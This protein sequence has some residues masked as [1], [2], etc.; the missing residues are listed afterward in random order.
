MGRAGDGSTEQRTYAGSHERR[1]VPALLRDLVDETR[2]LLQEEVRLAKVETRETLS[3][4]GRNLTGIAI[5][6]GLGL[7]ALLALAVA[8]NR[9]LTVLLAQGMPLEVAVWLAPL[10]IAMVFGVACAVLVSRGVKTIQNQSLV[11][12]KTRQTLK[13]DKEWLRSKTH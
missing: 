6:A 11:P 5:G 4:I 8:L 7:A 10:L 9:G 13:E 12:E 2:V 3:V 1:S